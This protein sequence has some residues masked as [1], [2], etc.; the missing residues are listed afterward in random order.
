MNGIQVTES[1]IIALAHN[2]GCSAAHEFLISNGKTY[3][4][5]SIPM[6]FL[7]IGGYIINVE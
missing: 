7:K 4:P 6:L 1:G 3:P 2:V 5:H